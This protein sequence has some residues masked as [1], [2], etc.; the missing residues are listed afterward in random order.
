[1]VLQEPEPS[2]GVARHDDSAVV[3]EALVWCRTEDY[4]A[5]EYY[6]KEAVKKAFDEG[7]I[8]IPFPQMDVHIKGG[9][10]VDKEAAHRC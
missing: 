6:M 9:E 5:T 10:N 2:I 3:I 7:G 8:D 4:F 1:M